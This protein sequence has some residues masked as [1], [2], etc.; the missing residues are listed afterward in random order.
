MS[1]TAKNYILI[2]L[3]ILLTGGVY[4]QIITHEFIS[5]DDP[6]YI[7]ENPMIARGL[8]GDTALWAINTFRAGFWIPLTWLSLLIDHELFGLFPGGF[9]LVNLILHVLNTLIVYLLLRRMTGAYWR[10]FLVALLFGIHP[11]H[12]ESVAWATERKDVLSTFFFLAAIWAYLIYLKKP[13]PLI[14]AWLVLSFVFSLM[15]KPMYVT[16]P[17]ALL[18]LD[19]WPLDR[20]QTAL[21]K[22]PGIAIFPNNSI[23][24]PV[25]EKIP[26]LFISA[27]FAGFNILVARATD[28]FLS[29]NS[30]P[31]TSRLGNAMVSYVAY[32]DKIIWPTNLGVLYPHPGKTLA[33][34]AILLSMAVLA[35]ITTGILLAGRGHRYLPCGWFWFLGILFPVS[36]L[37][38]NGYQA[39]A[40]R[41]VYIPALG[42]MIMAVW[43]GYDLTVK[44]KGIKTTMIT[45]AAI[46]LSA[47]FFR[48]YIQAHYWRNSL[49]LYTRTLAVTEN[50]YLMHDYAGIQLVQRGKLDEAYGHFQK[51][52]AIN[53]NYPDAYFNAGTYLMFHGRLA[54]AAASLER[55][56]ELG[57]RGK[58]RQ[59]AENNLKKT[60]LAA[61]NP[62]ELIAILEKTLL[63]KPSDEN[64]RRRLNNLAANQ[65]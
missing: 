56:L 25:L 65:R 43:G 12:V 14:Y 46:I 19:Y 45:L 55:S 24:Y 1:V 16:F 28:I 53:P 47:L 26:L 29:I 50:N 4:A 48:T 44:F 49:S 40:D 15:A 32:L 18:L 6:Y 51:A 63:L 59:R 54:E 7:T 61:E 22:K 35:L 23:F 2:V 52:M 64:L 33:L 36:G 10:S 38:Q 30:L 3:L 57:I 60:L 39:M 58:N 9:L 20:W 37:F 41:F 42:L 8:S 11:I 21:P 17:L 13:R 27:F 34:S 62:A 5:Y 31:L